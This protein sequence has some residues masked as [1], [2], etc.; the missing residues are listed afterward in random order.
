MNEDRTL[1]MDPAE[2]VDPVRTA[3]KALRRAVPGI[4]EPL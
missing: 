2:K 1:L 4:E 3:W